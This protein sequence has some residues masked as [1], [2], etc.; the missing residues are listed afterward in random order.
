MSQNTG[1]DFHSSPHS[2]SPLPLCP[3]GPP[4]TGWPSVTSVHRSDRL[5]FFPSYLCPWTALAPW[6]R[7]QGTGDH[8][9]SLDG[10]PPL[11]KQEEGHSA[12]DSHRRCG[13]VFSLFPLG[14]D[15]PPASAAAS[16]QGLKYVSGLLTERMSKI[17]SFIILL[18]SARRGREGASP[19]PWR[20]GLARRGALE[21][22]W[23]S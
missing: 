5:C 8:Q 2:G 15:L 16:M 1:Q 7:I 9:P 11:W 13:V 20:W 3:A 22:Q 6:E 18:V 10:S 19:A 12:H 21:E 17:K 23:R 14:A 4:G